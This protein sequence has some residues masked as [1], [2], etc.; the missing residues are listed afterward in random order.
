MV[1]DV[2]A[3]DLNLAPAVRT[4]VSPSRLVMELAAVVTAAARL[5]GRAPDG[6]DSLAGGIEDVPGSIEIGAEAERIARTLAVAGRGA[7]L[8]GP[9]AICHRNAAVLRGLAACLAD[10]TG[11]TLGTPGRRREPRGRMDR[12]SACRIERRTARQRS[13]AVSTRGR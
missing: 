12:R 13:G 11:A 4:V 7:I 2:M 8:L 9:Q 5:A 6:L 3:H 1:L 10:L